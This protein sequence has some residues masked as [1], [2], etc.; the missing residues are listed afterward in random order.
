VSLA[1]AFHPLREPLVF[2]FSVSRRLGLLCE[3]EARGW[4]SPIISLIISLVLALRVFFSSSG[5]AGALFTSGPRHLAFLCGGGR[6]I[7]YPFSLFLAFGA[8]NFGFTKVCFFLT[9]FTKACFFFTFV[10]LSWSALKKTCVSLP[11][12]FNRVGSGSRSPSSV[13]LP[14]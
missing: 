12:T 14:H 1:K 8:E 4:L 13:R 2:S 3:I 11:V 10:S 6:G 5:V 7:S 9:G